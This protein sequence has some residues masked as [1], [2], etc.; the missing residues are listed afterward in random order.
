MIGEVGDGRLVDWM[1]VELEGEGAVV[2]GAADGYEGGGTSD[3]CE[4][5]AG[6]VTDEQ[7]IRVISEITRMRGGTSFSAAIMISFIGP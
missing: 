5:G 6:A 2:A 3:T 4:V 1:G 7:E